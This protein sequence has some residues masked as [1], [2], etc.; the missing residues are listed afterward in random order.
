MNKLN[1][2]GRM[3]ISPPFPQSAFTILWNKLKFRNF[4]TNWPLQH[5]TTHFPLPQTP[6]TEELPSF[7]HLT[8]PVKKITLFDPLQLRKVTSNPLLMPPLI[9]SNS[10]LLLQL[11]PT[12][13]HQLYLFF[14]LFFYY[15]C[16][17]FVNSSLSKNL[18]PNSP[19]KK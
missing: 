14:T 16:N 8:S 13:I 19:Q 12:V 10:S 18:M 7:S 3:L 11:P 4:L 2:V 9:R 5:Y 15:S 1:L 6:L 17:N